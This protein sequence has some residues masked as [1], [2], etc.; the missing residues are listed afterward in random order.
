M[1]TLSLI[2]INNIERYQDFLEIKITDTIKTSGLNRKQP[3]LIIPRYKEDKTICPMSTLESYLQRTGD[4]RNS[5]ERLFISLKRP[6]KAIRSQT[7]SRW[8]KTTLQASGVDMQKF[9]PYST[10]HAATSAA[11]RGGVNLDSIRKAAGWTEESKTF[12]KFY[13]LQLIP[14]KTA[15]AKAILK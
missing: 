4:I 8:I 2:K 11:K 13:D 9:S 15:F 3:L 1:Q 5:V 10:R 14:D 6:Y 7:L 12:A